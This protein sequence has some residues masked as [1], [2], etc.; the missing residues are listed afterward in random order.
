MAF[1]TADLDLENTLHE[2]IN[3]T[4][5]YSEIQ[6]KAALYIEQNANVGSKIV[7]F[8]QEN[9]LLNEVKSKDIFTYSKWNT[10]LAN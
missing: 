7:V 8:L 3:D 9:K 6:L 10:I 2:T 1:C 5:K 4:D